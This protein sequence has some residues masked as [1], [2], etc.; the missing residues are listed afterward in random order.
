MFWQTGKMPEIYPV[1][2]T[3]SKLNINQ[4]GQKIEAQVLYIKNIISI[5]SEYQCIREYHTLGYKERPKRKF[6][7]KDESHVH[8]TL[9]VIFS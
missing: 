9:Q 5:N 8:I 7:G 4:P 2:K 1:T 3:K 6:K